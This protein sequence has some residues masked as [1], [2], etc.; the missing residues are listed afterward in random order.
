M[1]SPPAI[2]STS[3]PPPG[4]PSSIIATAPA[5]TRS[6]GPTATGAA[7][8]NLEIPYSLGFFIRN[9]TATNKNVVFV[10]HVIT[11]A[12][13]VTAVQN[14]NYVSRI[15]PVPM[16]LD[17][18]N[19]KDQLA[20]GGDLGSATTSTSQPVLPATGLPTTATARALIPVGWVDG[21]GVAAG[22]AP[23]TSAF[24]IKRLSATPVSV[25]IPIPAGLDL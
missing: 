9:S 6:A 18:S 10:G 22:T 14:F 2:I 11:T 15:L 12:T 17:A 16:T 4:S 25:T 24:L 21:S 3:P 7:A 8:A 13:K 23:L 20:Q 5:S 19:M 1:T